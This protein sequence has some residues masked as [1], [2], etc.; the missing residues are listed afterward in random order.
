MFQPVLGLS[1]VF[2]SCLRA[3]RAVS[4]AFWAVFRGLSGIVW[5][6]LDR[7]LTCLWL[8]GVVSS[9]LGLSRTVWSC[10]V[11]VSGCLRDILG[12]LGA[13][14]GLSWAVWGCVEL[15]LAIWGY[16]RQSQAIRNCLGAMCG[17]IGLLLGYLR[18]FCAVSSCL[19]LSWASLACWGYLRTVSVSLGLSRTLSGCLGLYLAFSCC[20]GA[21]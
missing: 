1:G 13:I 9:C 12:C 6:F 11:A 10:L 7:S 21:S 14:S 2:L 8:C 15:F 19:W 20:L 18:L 17:C 16:L 5:A 4:K 3:A